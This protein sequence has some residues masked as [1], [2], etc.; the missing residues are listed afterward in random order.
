MI[1]KSP[2][3]MERINSVAGSLSNI[4]NNVSTADGLDTQSLNRLAFKRNMLS[5]E[6]F[7]ERLWVFNPDIANSLVSDHSPKLLMIFSRTTE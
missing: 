6:K 4:A 3:S 7:V 5:P 2:T 1:V